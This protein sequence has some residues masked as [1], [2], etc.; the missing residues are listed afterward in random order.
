MFLHWTNRL[1]NLV[2]E[3]ITMENMGVK[4]GRYENIWEFYS[5]P[6]SFQGLL[7]FWANLCNA[8][9]WNVGYNYIYIHIYIYIYTYHPWMIWDANILFFSICLSE[10]IQKFN[11]LIYLY[12]RQ[13]PNG[14]RLYTVYPTAPKNSLNPMGTWGNMTSLQ[15]LQVCDQSVEPLCHACREYLTKNLP[16]VV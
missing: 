15:N 12:N 8:W 10:L 3:K 7:H 6:R 16:M 13:K 11:A 9:Y 4:R 5:Q 1:Y 2:W 14:L